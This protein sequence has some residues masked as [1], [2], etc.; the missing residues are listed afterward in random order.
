MSVRRWYLPLVALLAVGLALRVLA[1]AGYWPAYIANPDA[2][3]YL[4]AA[5]SDLFKYAERPSGYPI[6]LR[7]ADWGLFGHFPL[8]VALQHLLGLAAGVLIYLTAVR[9][10]ASRVLA[11]A[12]AAV[13]LLTGDQIFF[14]HAVLSEALF[15]FLVL[16]SVYCAARTLDPGALPW[17]VAAGALLAAAATVRTVGLF[18]LP[19]L[20]LW[21]V[22]TQPGRFRVR[23][24]PVLACVLSAVVVAGAYVVAQRDATGF[25][26]FAR[27]TGW[28]LYSRVAHFADCSKFTPP[29]GTAGLCEPDV[30]SDERPGATF[31]HHDS[32]SPAWQVFGPPPNGNEQLRTFAREVIINQPFAYARTVVKDALRY[33]DPDIGRY[34]PYNG[35]GPGGLSFKDPNPAYLDR[36]LEQIRLHWHSVSFH[37]RFGGALRGY[38]D[39]IRV[40]GY[41]LPLLALVALVGLW[42]A[43]RRERAGIA[44]MLGFTAIAVAVPSATLFYSWRYLVPLL[45]LLV[46]AAALGVGALL[47]RW[48]DRGQRAAPAG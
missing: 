40:H 42:P 11:L 9:F 19:L 13:V 36:S 27:T 23:A 30:P 38:Q 15:G 43:T 33:I 24:V 7:V 26:G 21:L 1:T 12:A 2:F 20:A 31:Y 25:T 45:P 39:V 48:A 4:D 18:M 41:L 47:R 37:D 6:F 32:R 34:R 3:S 5:G 10:G 29:E 28:S 46:A 22:L 35:T 8:L 14:E 16:A 17:A 44:L